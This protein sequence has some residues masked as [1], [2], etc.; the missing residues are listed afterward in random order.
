VGDDK[1]KKKNFLEKKDEKE[2]KIQI[3]PSKFDIIQTN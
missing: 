1:G 2:K 3:T